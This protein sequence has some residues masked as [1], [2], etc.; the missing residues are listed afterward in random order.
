[1]V[2][3][4]AVFVCALSIG[5]AVGM[6]E[7]LD[8]PYRGFIVVSPEPMLAALAQMQAQMN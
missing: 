3:I 4:A 7:D 1:M 2:T 5:S 8:Q 6:I